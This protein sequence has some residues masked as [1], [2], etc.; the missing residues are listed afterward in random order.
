MDPN[1]PDQ[2]INRSLHRIGWWILGLAAAGAAVWLL[3]GQNSRALAFALG[4]A[5]A[6]FG[7]RVHVQMADRFL[8]GARPRWLMLKVFLRYGLPILPL[9]AM[10]RFCKFDVAGFL[11]GLLLP[12]AAVMI[13]GLFLIIRP[14][15]RRG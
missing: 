14:G 1:P 6:Y 11:T 2:A 5:V 3:A 8:A 12:A 7:Y 10:I 13:E 9:Y 4:G 15:R